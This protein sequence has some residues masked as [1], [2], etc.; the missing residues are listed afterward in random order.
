VITGENR[1]SP[2]LLF[3]LASVFALTGCQKDSAPDPA[4]VSGTTAQDTST[5]RKQKKPVPDENGLYH[6]H[7]GDD[8]QR[9]L[10]AAASDAKH[11]DMVI[12][13]GTYRPAYSSQAMIRFHARH[14]GIVLK[15]DGEVILTAENRDLSIPGTPG[16]PAIVN[17]VIYIGHGVTS[18]TKLVGLQITGAN[19]FVTQSEDD[20]P[21]EPASDKPGLDK[22]LF[23]YLD[24]GAIKIFGDSSP[25]LDGL[26]IFG[27]RTLLCGAGISVEQRGLAKEPVVIQNCR[28]EDNACPAT[29]TAIDLLEG[30]KA[31]ITNCLFTDN[32]GNTGMAAVASEYGLKYHETHGSGAL[33]VFPGSSACTDRC[34]FTR[35]WNAVDDHGSSVYTNCIFY[36]NTASDG[37]LPGAPYEMDVAGTVK[38]EDCWLK[39][40]TDDLRGTIDATHNR[41]QAP[42]PDF[43]EHFQPRNPEYKNAGW[44]KP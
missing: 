2:A 24:G 26:R 27:N 43:D 36:D 7:P 8:L 30:S 12:H 37:S 31:T 23:F 34:T 33:T 6:I 14:D 11:K 9:I 25:V 4:S 44:R 22:R 42:D 20:G 38:V 3:M 21:I 15:A 40:T 18:R 16:Y 41:L 17:H 29:G 28:F 13:A 5:D 35:N 19:G 32:I 10:D 1:R 39:G